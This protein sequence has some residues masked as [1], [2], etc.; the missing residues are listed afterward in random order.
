MYVSGGGKKGIELWLTI[1]NY[2]KSDISWK[3]FENKLQLWPKETAFY[4]H[5]CKSCGLNHYFQIC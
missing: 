5:R 3:S 2:G 4:H 1:G